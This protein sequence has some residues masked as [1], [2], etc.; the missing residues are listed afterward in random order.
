MGPHGFHM[1]LP[2]TVCGYAHACMRGPWH[3]AQLG[4][5]IPLTRSQHPSFAII[6]LGGSLAKD[7]IKYCYTRNLI[8]LRTLSRISARYSFPS[9]SLPST[10]VHPP[11][12]VSPSVVRTHCAGMRDPSRHPLDLRE[13]A[14]HPVPKKAAACDDIC[15][16]SASSLSATSILLDCTGRLV[17]YSS[18][19]L[20]ARRKKNKYK[21][22]N[23]Y[24][25]KSK[26]KSQKAS[27]YLYLP[28]N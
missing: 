25:L 23:S 9:L 22:Y 18:R 1:S 16:E 4:G 15:R 14:W 21:T 13:N 6:P 7:L 28:L 8:P 19:A 26:R 5:P 10:T 17:K 24:F 11:R 3:G 2:P 27:Y 12:P 20:C